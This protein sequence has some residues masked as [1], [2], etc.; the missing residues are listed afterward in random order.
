MGRERA[1]DREVEKMDPD[2]ALFEQEFGRWGEKVFRPI[3]R[4][5]GVVIAVLDRRPRPR[6]WRAPV[7]SASGAARQDRTVGEGEGDRFRD[8]EC[9]GLGPTTASP[10]RRTFKATSG[11]AGETLCGVCVAD[12]S[13][14]G[15]DPGGHLHPRE[16]SDYKA[17][18]L[19]ATLDTHY[20]LIVSFRDRHNY[21]ASLLR[22]S[23]VTRRIPSCQKRN[24]AIRGTPEAAFDFSDS[25]SAVGSRRQWI[26]FHCA[27]SLIS[28]RLSEARCR[29]SIASSTLC[30]AKRYA[31]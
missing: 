10:C 28:E 14:P 25:N 19:I 16:P 11:V 31:R 2:S 20:I 6:C 17:S 30:K 5:E 27:R 3:G 23:S 7:R 24:L 29:K 4:L 15:G 1:F 18:L 26:T 9:S 22:A 13:L 8:S 12:E 21:G